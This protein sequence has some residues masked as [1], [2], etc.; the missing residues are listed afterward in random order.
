MCLIVGREGLWGRGS[1]QALPDAV[2]SVLGPLG[3]AR[4]PRNSQLSGKTG[5]QMNENSQNYCRGCWES[6]GEGQREH[7]GK[8]T[9]VQG[10]FHLCR[11]GNRVCEGWKK[12]CIVQSAMC[13]LTGGSL[14]APQL[15]PESTSPGV[16]FC[17]AG[18]PDSSPETGS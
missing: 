13:S 6:R 11:P 3:P 8:K 15:S 4:R 12:W 16:S 7:P 18:L 10:V 1:G 17:R 9:D 2:S 14:H 5:G